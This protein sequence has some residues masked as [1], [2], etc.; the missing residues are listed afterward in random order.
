[1]ANFPL[2]VPSPLS[3]VDGNV[4]T[5]A[6]AL[7]SNGN[8]HDGDRKKS[9]KEDKSNSNKSNVRTGKENARRKRCRMVMSSSPMK[10]L[11]VLYMCAGPVY[12]QRQQW[13]DRQIIIKYIFWD[14][15]VGNVFNNGLVAFIMEL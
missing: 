10:T 9:S 15:T 4:D 1:M 2:S 5:L 12:I 8:K 6:M 11:N 13:D 7:A 14:G 3:L